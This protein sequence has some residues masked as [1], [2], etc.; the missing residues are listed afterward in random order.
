MRWIKNYILLLIAGIVFI[1]N[2]SFYTP[3]QTD[4]QE[5]IL[6]A[7]FVSRFADYIEWANE[8]ETNN[9]TIGILG[10][11]SIAA[12]L[13]DIAKDKKIKNKSILIKSCKNL[14]DINSCQIIFVSKN[15]D[16]PIETIVSKLGNNPILLIT[17]QK[18]ACEKGAHINFLITDN[19]LK[20]EINLKAALKAGFKISSQLLQH[21]I[22]INT[23]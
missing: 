5:Y 2:S 7:A 10:E 6:K 19:K 21:A 4:S 22:L 14:D 3:A 1:A 11:S 17:E 8:N 15:Y 12:P 23:E 18:D 9:F 16:T 20:F 13:N